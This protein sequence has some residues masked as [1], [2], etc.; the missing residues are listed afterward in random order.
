[1]PFKVTTP[2]ALL[3]FLFLK[4]P[5]VPRTR[6]K[7]WLRLGCVSVNGK[8]V[9]RHDLA[10]T[11]K[12]TVDVTPHKKTALAGKS[13]VTIVFQDDHLVVIDKPSGLLTVATEKEKEKTVY[14]KLNEWLRE[15][16]PDRPERVFIVHRLDRETSGLIVFA[17]NE[18]AK[19]ALQDSWEKTEKLYYAVV[20][21]VPSK[22]EDILKSH[23]AQN[24]ILKVY[25]TD[26]ERPSKLAVTHYR[27]IRTDGKFSLLEVMPRTGRK[28]QIRVQLADIGHPVAGGEKYGAQSDPARRLAL[29]AHQLS[30][31]HPVSGK[32]LSFKS[33]LPS[34]LSRIVR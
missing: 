18:T 34:L 26:R 11:L 9:T 1:M 24:T 28:N 20:E 15:A 16:N 21:G 13:P 5:D 27:V 14:F 33:P 23:L 30:F 19:Y 12:D 2:S 3:P 8:S 25:A 7:K 10:L 31:R 4:F 32:A 29:H 22:K 17:K 6:V